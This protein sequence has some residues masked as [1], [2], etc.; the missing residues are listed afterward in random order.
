[1][2][3]TWKKLSKNRVQSTKYVLS[4]PCHLLPKEPAHAREYVTARLGIF[5][6]QTQLGGELW[7]RRRNVFIA[8]LAR[9]PTIKSTADGSSL[10]DGSFAND[11]AAQ[12]V[13]LRDFE[14]VCGV[15]LC[16]RGE[17]LLVANH[18]PQRLKHQRAFATDN[19]CVLE[20]IP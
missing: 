5:R 19:R 11:G 15:I 6:R 17:K 7:I 12:I 14:S 4:Y 13:H 8:I 16:Q 10:F 9:Q 20:R 18:F 3:A 1:M 2:R